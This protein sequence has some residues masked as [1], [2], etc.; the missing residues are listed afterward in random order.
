MRGRGRWCLE[1]M[2]AAMEPLTP[3]LSWE[4]REKRRQT[5]KTKNEGISGWQA[6]WQKE[7]SADERRWSKAEAQ[8]RRGGVAEDGG[9]AE[10]AAVPTWGISKPDERDRGLG[11]GTADGQVTDAGGVG[12]GPVDQQS[13]PNGDDA[14]Q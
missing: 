13:G 9:V 1:P 2:I 5:D 10:V 14:V 12:G 6:S 8:Q 3:A 11:V 4:A 7:K